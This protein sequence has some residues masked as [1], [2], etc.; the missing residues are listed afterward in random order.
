MVQA[1]DGLVTAAALVGQPQLV[2]MAAAARA[3]TPVT[4]ATGKRY[5]RQA[6]AELLAVGATHPRM[7]GALVV[8]LA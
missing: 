3:D 2:P 7:D 1:A 4:A 5:R 6:V 8:V